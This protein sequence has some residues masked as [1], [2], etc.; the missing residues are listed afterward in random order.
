MKSISIEAFARD[1]E[2]LPP[3][4]VI[5][6]VRT[7]EE[8]AAG[9]VPGAINIPHDQMQTRVAEVKS[10]V[11]GNRPLCIYCRAGAR[12]Q[13]AA[14]VLTAGGVSNLICV[15]EGGMPD[16]IQAGHPVETIPPA[17]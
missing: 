10:K 12:A 5:L 4:T 16:W 6:D 17:S 9:H 2:T 3:Q 15:T 1:F 13:V 14:G 7:P 11:A 8:Y